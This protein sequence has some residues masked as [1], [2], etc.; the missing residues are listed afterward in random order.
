MSH[1]YPTAGTYTVQLNG[2]ATNVMFGSDAVSRSNLIQSL[3]PIQGVSRL[4]SMS[5]AF[6]NCYQLNYQPSNLFQ[7]ACY[8]NVADLY[9]TWYGCSRMTNFPAVSNLIGVTRLYM[10]WAYCFNVTN[11]F[12][13]VS[14]LTN[15]TTCVSAW[16][17]NTGYTGDIAVIF[18]NTNAGMP[19]LTT[20]S[21]AFANCNRMTG[22]G[23]RFVNMS[24]SATYWANTNGPAFISCAKT[25]LNCTNLSD[26]AIIPAEY[27]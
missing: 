10:T 21:N 5:N 4:T 15:L 2:Y 26:Y 11:D 23:M 16:A 18:A 6:L 9:Q 13:N 3:G 1:Y 7:Y 12:P 20:S 8:T 27:K 22:N 24:K 25:F 14:P 19:F 17:N